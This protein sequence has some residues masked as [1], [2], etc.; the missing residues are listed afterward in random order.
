MK[1][2]CPVCD[3]LSVNDREVMPAIAVHR[4]RHIV[5]GYN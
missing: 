2:D 5:G 4:A 3:N 1:A